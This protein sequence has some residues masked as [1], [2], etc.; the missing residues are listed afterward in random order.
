MADHSDLLKLLEAGQLEPYLRHIRFF[1]Y[2][3]LTDGLRVEFT[4]PITAI[5]GPNGTN[6]SSILRAV[7]GAQEGVSLGRYWFGTKLDIIGE[8]KPR[9]I[10]GWI[11]PSIGTVVEALKGRVGRT[12]DP[13]YWEPIR[14]LPTLGMDPMPEGEGQHNTKRGQYDGDRSKTRWNAIPKSVT[15]IDFRSE[16]SAFDKYF[17][18]A[19]HQDRSRL[20]G[21]LARRRN[22]VRKQSR[23]IAESI[24]SQR[25]SHVFQRSERILEPSRELSSDELNAIKYILDRPYTRIDL[26]HHRYYNVP[27]HT[28]LMRTDTLNYSEAFAGSGEFAVIMLVVG[29]LGSQNHSLIL[30]DEPETSLHPG[31]QHRLMKFLV[32]Q[33]A[34]KKLQVI[35]ATH[36]PALVENL[37]AEAIKVLD[38]HPATGKVYLRSQAT[39]HRAAF[40]RLGQSVAKQRVLVEDR[41]AQVIVQ[42]AVKVDIGHEPHEFAVEVLGGG[43]QAMMSACVQLALSADQSFV[44][45]DADMRPKEL[46]PATSDIASSD[47]ETVISKNFHP[48]VWSSVK[49]LATSMSGTE[50]S[51]GLMF[52]EWARS[53]IGYLPGSTNPESWLIDKMHMDG[54]SASGVDPKEFWIATTQKLL[55]KER[56]TSD[57]ILT[58]QEQALATV[59]HANLAPITQEI[60]RLAEF[61]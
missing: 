55:G 58:I 27:G 49:G 61:Q 37:P 7:E 59:P 8:N 33:C 45:L 54:S 5:V 43:A 26:L 57:E 60:D 20:R 13:D 12:D 18:H 17:Y 28:A 16:L 23:H 34:R 14:S 35:F 24:V 44:L 50:E 51:L 48:S 19:P 11:A 52:I 46:L 30:L 21:D 29:V 41:L 39:H 56:V 9:V 6:K 36:A 22:R 53:H 2:K 25:S 10:H 15:Y 40:V 3:N 42:R 47:I 4:H 38:L 1:G 31:A 32:D